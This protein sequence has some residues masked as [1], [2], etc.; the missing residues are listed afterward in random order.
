MKTES[1]MEMCSEWLHNVDYGRNSAQMKEYIYIMCIYIY[2]YVCVY[3]VALD[4]IYIHTCKIQFGAGC[5]VPAQLW[6]PKM[7]HSAA[8][9]N[10]CLLWKSLWTFIFLVQ[11]LPLE[12]SYVLTA[13][14]YV[15]CFQSRVTHSA[16]LHIMV[17]LCKLSVLLSSRYC[18]WYIPLPFKLMVGPSGL[19]SQLQEHNWTSA[20]PTQEAALMEK[21]LLV[22]DGALSGCRIKKA[23]HSFLSLTGSL[24]SQLL[25]CRIKPLLKE[26][27]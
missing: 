17:P 22:W 26:L 1:T 5:L 2:M 3:I 4:N 12:F 9:W 15:A 25:H 7:P 11:S 18:I 10:D 19:A 27:W 20:H 8:F 13:F 16:Y 6:C 23:L 14:A 21:C 24:L